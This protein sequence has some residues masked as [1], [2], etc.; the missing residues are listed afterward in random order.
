MIAATIVPLTLAQARRFVADHHRHNEP[1]VGHR[2]S[3]GLRRDDGT[4]AGVVIAGRPVARQADDGLTLE[5]LRIVTPGSRVPRGRPDRGARGLGAY[6][7][8]A[9][10]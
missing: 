9:G 7:Q 5:L 4:L 6:Q 8:A 10:R 2:F 1:P 3:I